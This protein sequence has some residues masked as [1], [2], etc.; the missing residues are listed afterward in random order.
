MVEG[1]GATRHA[2]K[3]RCFVGCQ[4][5]KGQVLSQV[6]SVGKEVF[7]IFEN[8]NHAIRLHFGM[9]GSLVFHTR[10][11]NRYGYNN[12]E[13]T[14]E[15]TFLRTQHS[16]RILCYSTTVS[17]LTAN[18]ARSK[19][20]RLFCLDVCSNDDHFDHQRVLQALRSRPHSMLTDVLLDQSRFPG[21][22]NIIKVE[23]LHRAKLHPKRRVENCS[24]QE[25]DRVIQQCRSY[26]MDWYKHGRAP[27][28]LVYNQ[29]TC[30]TCHNMTVRIEKMGTDLSR[31]TFW[32]EHCQPLIQADT[33]SLST[34]TTLPTYPETTK[35]TDISSA[36]SRLLHCPQH[37]TQTVR[38]KRVR[39]QSSPNVGRIFVSCSRCPAF[40]QWADRHLTCVKCSKVH[41]ILRISK[42]AHSGG[43][44]FLSC[45]SCQSFSWA[46]PADLKPLQDKLTPLL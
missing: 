29:T 31:T 21:V 27:R 3:A 35:V 13:P 14:F 26:A 40:F 15:M 32:C 22:G 8:D 38:L 43:K 44:W 45:P 28:K 42:T 24:D 1:P 23:G 37:G 20:E 11:N 2:N 10:Q 4:N 33:K 34:T 12:D 41:R 30:Q 17:T 36:S 5:E 25:L 9:N 6:F 7:L 46:Q 39:K 16:E 19:F 18:I